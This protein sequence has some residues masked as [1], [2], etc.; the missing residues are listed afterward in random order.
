MSITYTATLPVRDET[1]LP[2]SALLHAERLRRGTRHGRRALTCYRQAVLVL[3]RLLD[4][5][6]MS[7]LARDNT[8]SKSTGYDNLH[9][10][11]AVL[12]AQAPDLHA[13]LLAAKAA[14]YD[15]VLL[16]GTLIETDRVSTP[17]PTPGVDL[18]W[19]K[20]HKNHGGNIQVVCAPDGWPLWTS[21]VRPGREHDTRCLRTHPGLLTTLAEIRTDL[22]TLA[23][24]GYEGE[25]STIAVAFKTPKNGQ[26]TDIQQ[27]FN[28]A[29][30]RLRAIGERGNSILKTTFKAL[31]NVTVCPWKIGDI[32]AAALVILHIEHNR[33][34]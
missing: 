28:H 13:A 11:I 7:Q 1:V 9:E 15:Y 21:P 30:N 5:T 16:D 20:K 27:Q 23:D 33:T 8:I 34:T 25:A 6:R 18:W 2:V 10:G 31:R 24:L 19:S 12:A 17:G 14:G 3:R 29:H 22:R 26:L 4:G 32:V